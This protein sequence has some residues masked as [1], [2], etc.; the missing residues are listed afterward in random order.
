MRTHTCTHAHI[1]NTRA[2]AGVLQS[3]DGH[4]LSARGSGFRAGPSLWGV[5]PGSWLGALRP[6]QAPPSV[7]AAAGEARWTLSG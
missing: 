6:C 5:A 4:A 3:S 1:H 2:H 7:P